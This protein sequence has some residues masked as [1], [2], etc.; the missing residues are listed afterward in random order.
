MEPIV[1]QSRCRFSFKSLGH[2][3]LK[4]LVGLGILLI[5]LG[6]PGAIGQSDRSVSAPGRNG[7][8]RF[9]GLGT[10]V[11]PA[12]PFGLEILGPVGSAGS[13]AR[14]EVM[15]ES[16]ISEL[17]GLYKSGVWYPEQQ[18]AL[19][20]IDPANILLK[21][22][23]QARAYFLGFQGE[24]N[25]GF[26]LNVNGHGLNGGDPKL[27]L[28]AVISRFPDPPLGMKTG[29]AA[30]AGEFVD[31]GL[32]QAGS[33]LD[34]FLIADAGNAGSTVASLDPK[35]N[36]DGFQHAMAYVLPESPYLI[37]GFEDMIN[38][39]EKDY[40]D[41]VFALEIG[42]ENIRYLTFLA[43]NPEPSEYALMALFL[44]VGYRSVRRTQAGRKANQH[45]EN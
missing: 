16:K 7:G 23:Y 29:Q 44:L 27:I 33:V 6:H 4:K 21:T 41:A 19:I 34:L 31:L 20:E 8:D 13:D 3:G 24:S 28:P 5:L 15:N 9:N 26:G 12:R 2:I 43:T 36:L 30:Q 45:S 40:M 17:L 37:L 22:D 1:S 14:S 32:I 10:G 38:G 18:N 42:E 39:G 25:N 35:Y 11:N